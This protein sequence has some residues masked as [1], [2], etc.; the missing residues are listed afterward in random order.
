MANLSV[1]TVKQIFREFWLPFVVAF[2]WTTYILWGKALDTKGVLTAFGPSFFLASWMTGQFFRVRKQE[3]V[4][5]GLASVETRLQNL[6]GELETQT[7]EITHY[8]TGGDS[9][10]YFGASINGNIANLAVVH[11]GKYPLYNVEARIVDLSKFDAAMTSGNPFA[12]DTNIRIGD[13][14]QNQAM[15]AHSMDLGTGDFHDFNIF[16]TAR[17][18]FFNQLLRF[19]RVGG[20]WISATSVTSMALSALDKNPVLQRVPEGYPVD[21]DGNPDGI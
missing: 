21:A 18:G 9:F 8:T 11:E 10:C 7:R 20:N 15:F 2:S 17:N 16:F 3:H 4:Q 5:S 12:A 6:I 19:R 14:A 1:R 13:I